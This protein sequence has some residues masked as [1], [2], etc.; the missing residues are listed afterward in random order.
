[1]T[2]VALISDMHGNAVAFDAVLAEL[3]REPFDAV[4]SLGDVAQGGPQPRDCVDRLRALGCRCVLGNSDEF[5]LTLDPGDDAP[6]TPEE[7]ERL[8]DVGRWSA[9]RLGDDGLAFLRS[10]EP[11]VEVSLDGGRTL[12]CCHGSP[13]S[14]EEIVLPETTREDVERAT[15]ADRPDVV[16]G[17]HVH[18]QWHRRVGETLWLC[19]GSVG[20]AYEH[21]VEPPRADRWAE[22]AVLEAEGERLRLEFRR[23]GYDVERMLAATAAS[24]RPHAEAWTAMWSA[25]G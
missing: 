15:G 2:R 18:L 4:V 24:G 17:G 13:R 16:A 10:F 8:L 6:E 3:E 11:T 21:G 19:A 20:L 14:N 5:L 9:E 23:V 12:L 25:P 7:L 1:V 22:Y